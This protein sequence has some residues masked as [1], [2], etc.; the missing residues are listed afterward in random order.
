M[1]RLGCQPAT[2]LADLGSYNK[3][4]ISKARAIPAWVASE[5]SHSEA[6]SSPEGDFS[7]GG[8]G[9]AQHVFR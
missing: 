3:T 1:T 2:K 5:P 6:T 9:L 8:S 7:A 4:H